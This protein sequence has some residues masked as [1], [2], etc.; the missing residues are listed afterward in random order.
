MYHEVL[1][2]GT[3]G[4][5]YKY[6]IPG[7]FLFLNVQLFSLLIRFFEILFSAIIELMTVKTISNNF[8]GLR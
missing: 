2:A 1:K 6:C 5:K 8:S 3:T 4:K 7:N